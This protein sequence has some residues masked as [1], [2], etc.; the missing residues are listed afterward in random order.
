M[1]PRVST[2]MLRAVSPTSRESIQSGA[3]DHR[4][5]S[6]VRRDQ[7]ILATAL[8]GNAKPTGATGLSVKWTLIG[9]STGPLVLSGS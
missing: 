3:A 2:A 8:N 4:R 7:W 9:R 5:A 6:S 1:A